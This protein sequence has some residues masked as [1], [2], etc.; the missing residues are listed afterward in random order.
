MK[1]EQ[2]KETS[3]SII[4]GKLRVIE[5]TQ[6]MLILTISETLDSYKKLETE[7]WLHQGTPFTSIETSEDLVFQLLDK[8]QFN[9]DCLLEIKNRVNEIF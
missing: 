3:V 2:V 7:S 8:L 1:E 9:N 5:E 4:L 6:R